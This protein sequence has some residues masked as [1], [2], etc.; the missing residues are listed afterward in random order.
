[1]INMRSEHPYTVALLDYL[2]QDY[3]GRGRRYEE[4][5]RASNGEQLGKSQTA[6]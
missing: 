4:R 1:M 5:I 3:K 2:L 6:K